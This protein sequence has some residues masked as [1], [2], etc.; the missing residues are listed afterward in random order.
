MDGFT[1]ECSPVELDEFLEARS[2][3]N[4]RSF[5]RNHVHLSAPAIEGRDQGDKGYGTFS[6]DITLDNKEDK[7]EDLN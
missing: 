2:K 7:G 6:G 4:T 1:V 3:R 5:V